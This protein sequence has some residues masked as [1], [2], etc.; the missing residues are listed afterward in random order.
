MR[1]HRMHPTPA[2]LLHLRRA[3]LAASAVAMLCAVAPGTSAFAQARPEPPPMPQCPAGDPQCT[4]G[5]SRLTLNGDTYQTMMLS[6][7]ADWSTQFWV[8][9]AQ[10]QVLLA[11]PPLRGNAYLAVQRA[12]DGR[13]APNPAVRLI[14]FH[15]APGDAAVAPS[16]LASTIYR[17]DAASNSLVADDT[18]VQPIATPEAI[19]QM[20]TSDGWT[21]VFPAN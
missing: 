2:G 9:D 13:P 7:G 3:L 12:D 11:I 1:R 18:T 20:L 17:Y 14:S 10:E 6:G 19:R 8:R 21:L 16:G 15:Y 5:E 4:Y